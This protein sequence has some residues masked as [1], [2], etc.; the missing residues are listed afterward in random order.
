MICFTSLCLIKKD[1]ALKKWTPEMLKSTFYDPT[2]TL[3]FCIHSFI[4]SFIPLFRHV[5]R[6][7]DAPPKSA[8]RST[9]SQKGGQTW[10]FCIRIKGVRFKKSTF[11]VQKV[12]ILG[13][14]HLSKIDPGDG[15]AFIHL[16]I[17]SFIFNICFFTI[18]RW[19]CYA[20]HRE[21][22]IKMNKHRKKP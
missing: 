16:C 20:P 22:L 9:F 11:W 19:L 18:M 8:K 15:P 14:P 12:H 21:C 3:I 10:V 7:C 17:H 4:H 6:G 1:K 13:I 5:A 2:T